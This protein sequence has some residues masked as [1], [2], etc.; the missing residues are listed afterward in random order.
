MEFSCVCVYG[1][2]EFSADIHFTHGSKKAGHLA[3]LETHSH[4]RLQQIL[5]CRRNTVQLL[6]A[7][8]SMDSTADDAHHICRR[9]RTSTVC[10]QREARMV[11]HTD[12]ARQCRLLQ[13]ILGLE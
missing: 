10:T 1:G 12:V 11:L 7:A 2:R 5:T 8:A 9:C 6:T 3:L 13:E 4:P